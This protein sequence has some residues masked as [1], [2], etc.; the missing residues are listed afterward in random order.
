MR[1]PQTHGFVERFQRTV[2]DEFFRP[3]FRTKF[4]D[5]V[6]T[7]QDDLDA[8]LVHY[9]TERAHQGYRNLGKRPFDTIHLYLNSVQNET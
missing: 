4:Y 5:R 2:L 1:R 6:E 7:L 3:A 8:W 9:N